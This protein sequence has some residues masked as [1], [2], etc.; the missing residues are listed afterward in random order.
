MC[1]ITSELQALL[2]SAVAGD[3]LK[4]LVKPR[5][6]F[7]LDRLYGSP[8]HAALIACGFELSLPNGLKGDIIV[9]FAKCNGA[10]RLPVAMLATENRHRWQEMM[11][12]VYPF[13]NGQ[14]TKSVD[15]PVLECPAKKPGCS[16]WQG[17]HRRDLCCA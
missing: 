10:Y 2:V 14:K 4:A 15:H 12:K 6:P 11:A 17:H 9:T 16:C 13:P 8:D 1:E 5:L 3:K 7:L